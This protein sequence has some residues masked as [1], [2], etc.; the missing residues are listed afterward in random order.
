[1]RLPTFVALASAPTPRLDHL[2]LA[3][4]VELRDDVNTT[5]AL[6]EL[7]RLGAELAPLA[8]RGAGA[9]AEAEACRRLLGETYG[10]EG[11]GDEYDDSD[12]SML[13]LVLARRVGL[14]ILLSTVYVEVARRAGIALAGVGLP[15]H[16]VVGH[17]GSDPP[18]LL[19]PYACGG[20]IRTAVDPAHMRPWGPHETALRMLNNLVGSYERR[21][22]LGRALQAAELRLLLPL[23]APLR[24]EIELSLKRVRARLN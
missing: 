2:A 8:G 21:G 18:L 14:P 7:D 15:G 6:A 1:M 10:F 3:L 9:E 13:D 5:W 11:H 22:D 20:R 16:F 24:T 17:F 19:D 12:N 4:A 23:S